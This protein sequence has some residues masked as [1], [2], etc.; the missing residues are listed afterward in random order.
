MVIQL[1]LEVLT[2]PI[3]Q[4]DDLLRDLNAGTNLLLEL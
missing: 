4:S 3:Q 1:V 2:L